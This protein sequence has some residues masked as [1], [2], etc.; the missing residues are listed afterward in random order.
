[1]AAVA[2]SSRKRIPSSS[3]PSATSVKPRSPRASTSTGATSR[4]RAA[5]NASVE[6]RPPALDLVVE[7][8]RV[9]CLPEQQPGVLGARLDGL[10]ADARLAPSS[11]SR[12]RSR[13]G[14]A[15]SRAR[16]RW[17]RGRRSAGR[18]CSRYERYAR[19]RSS[20]ERPTSRP[21]KVATASRSRVSG[22]SSASRA[23]LSRS[24]L[25]CQSK[26]AIAS[27][28]AW[29][30]VARRARPAIRWWKE[31]SSSVGGRA[32]GPPPRES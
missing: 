26:R 24:R 25:S 16:A 29:S 6:Q 8:D 30:E 18:R 1:M 7:E 17:R 11:R 28:A 2:A 13:P 19:W 21:Q 23:A 9:A 4:R 14:G 15:G 22:V 12:P 27:R 5:S 3:L 32:V 20:I 31:T 10:R